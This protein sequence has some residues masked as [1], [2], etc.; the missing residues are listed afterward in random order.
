MES[1]SL[2]S[3]DEDEGREMSGVNSKNAPVPYFQNDEGSLMHLYESRLRR[4]RDYE[5]R[6]Y[7]RCQN[8]DAPGDERASEAWQ[9]SDL[10]GPQSRFEGFYKQQPRSAFPPTAIHSIRRDP[11]SVIDV[12]AEGDNLD[13]ITVSTGLNSALTPVLDVESAKREPVSKETEDYLQIEFEN[14]EPTEDGGNCEILSHSEDVESAD[15]SPILNEGGIQEGPEDA[16]GETDATSAAP[17]QDTGGG[18]YTYSASA[19]SKYEIYPILVDPDQDDRAV[20]IALYSAKRPHMRA[21]HYAWLG[22]FVA[23]FN[24]FGIAPLMSEVAHSLQI[25]RTQVWT[26]NTMAVVGSF[27]TRLMAGPLNDIYGARLV[28]TCSLLISAIPGIISGVAIQGAISLYIIRFLVG[29]AGCAFV[30]CQFWTSKMFTTEVAGTALSLTA[31]WGNLGGG[32]SQVVMGSL[33]FPLFKVIYGGEAYSKSGTSVYPEDSNYSIDVPADKAWRTILAIP[34]IMCLYVAYVSLKYSEDLPKGNF[35]KLKLRGLMTQ[36]SAWSAILRATTNKN[37]WLMYIQYG[38]CFGVELTMTS[39]AALYF[40]EEFG[41]TTASAAAIASVFGWMNLFA[42]GLGGFCSD[43]A[44]A[45]YGMRGRLWVQV[46]FLVCQGSLVC[47]FSTTSTLSGAIV[48]MVIFSIFVQAAEGSSFAIVPYIDYSVTGSISGLVGAGGN[49]GAIIFSLLFRQNHNRA[50][51]FYMGC[52]VVVSSL[53]SAL[54]NIDGH[55][56]LFFG[57]DANEVT[58]RRTAHAGQV[59][60]VPVVDF[61]QSAGTHQNRHSVLRVETNTSLESEP[62]KQKVDEPQSPKLPEDD[63]EEVRSNSS[64]IGEA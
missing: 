50:A 60:N 10:D 61:H 46:I 45:N 54:V 62:G 33:L 14:P 23:F 64:E 37:T 48:V 52:A 41:Q 1:G 40:Q 26:A 34:G 3:S 58:D 29:I 28:M 15:K 36:E 42:R 8:S 18:N 49:F 9:N 47:V 51:F 55:R 21:F 19:D 35:R 20:E 43:M 30:T 13:D 38:C 16:S 63:F 6:V 56:S 53:L 59:G 4:I 2:K 24:W 11:P 31:G 57:K 25:D 5:S 7:S 44:S 17:N 27:I 12:G 39:A 32:V 22:F